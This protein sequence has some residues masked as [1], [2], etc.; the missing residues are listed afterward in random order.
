MRHDIKVDLTT[1]GKRIDLVVG[2]ALGLSRARVKAL[3]EDG[4]VRINHKKAKKGL[5][6]AAGDALE[7]DVPEAQ[8]STA[9]TAD[10]NL[11]VGILHEDEAL[12]FVDKPAGVP[13]QPL[14]PG[15]QGTVA[16]ALI[17]KYPEMS[18]VG[19]DPREAGLC[20][21]LDVETSGV[22]LAARTRDAWEK[23]RAAFSEERAV[24]KKY[25]ALVKGPLADEGTIDVPLTHAGDH[26]VPGMPDGRPAI[27]EFSVRARRGSY[28][29]VDVKLI[30][31]VLHQVRAHLAAVGAPIVG[32]S[33]Y[34]GAAEPGLERFFLH[35]VS[36]GVRHPITGDF[37]RVESP[38]PADLAKV[39]DARLPSAEPK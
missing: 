27:T 26:V 7:I 32:D 16:N 8:A 10:A 39:L 22:L 25:L 1:A 38:L 31:G 23:L 5:M 4:L 37:I 3:F 36:L 21:R 2:E 9:A 33:L 18:S 12:V 14:Q 28:A 29:L 20:H 24:E 11:V 35:A 15:E 30:T 6:V 19:D 13:S 34:G 17:S